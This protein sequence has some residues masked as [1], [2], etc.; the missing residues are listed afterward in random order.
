MSIVIMHQS[1]RVWEMGGGG[2]GVAIV[3]LKP[4]SLKI[5]QTGWNSKHLSNT[6]Q[7]EVLIPGIGKR[8]PDFFPMYCGR[9]QQRIKKLV[10]TTNK[11]SIFLLSSFNARDNRL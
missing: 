10:A 8:F 7:I 11:R 5:F 6:G 1:R 4:E 3:D 2:G 9:T